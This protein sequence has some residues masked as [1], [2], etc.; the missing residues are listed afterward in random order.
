MVSIKII[1]GTYGYHPDGAVHPIPIERGSC[2]NVPEAE[3][4]RLIALGVAELAEQSSAAGVATGSSDTSA[5]ERGVD[6]VDDE[7]AAE[8]EETALL[9]EADLLAMKMDELRALAADFGLNVRKMRS[10]AEI[11]LAISAAQRAALAV[12]S[13]PDVGV[14]DPVV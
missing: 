11:A 4:S 12:E 9:S 5:T 6:T 7:I 13:Q 1:C 10:K 8:G 2:C 14:L 3:A